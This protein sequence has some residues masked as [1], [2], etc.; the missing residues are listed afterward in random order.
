MD[1]S[2]QEKTPISRR[3]M[4]L[5]VKFSLPEKLLILSIDDATGKINPKFKRTQQLVV[6]AAILAELMLAGKISLEEGRLVVSDSTHTEDKV[7]D[8]ALDE[9]ASSKKLRKPMRWITNLGHKENLRRVAECLAERKV[10]RIEARHYVFLIPYESYSP[11]PASA[12]FWIKRH[13]REVVLVGKQPNRADVALLALLQACELSQ[14]VF[15]VEER[16]AAENRINALIS[17]MAEHDPKTS[18]LLA[19]AKAAAEAKKAIS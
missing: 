1:S 7:L 2:E 16:K 4:Q 15:T 12:K 14:L 18:Q 13:L 17:E 19:I 9:I 10:F 5:A 8:T 6:S 3:E 11:R